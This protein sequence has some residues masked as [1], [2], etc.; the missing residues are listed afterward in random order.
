[1]SS[2][3]RLVAGLS[4][5]RPGFDPR[6]VHVG[7]VV[8][9]VALGQDFPRVLRFSPVSF[10]PPV[11]HYTEKRKTLIIFITGLHNKPQVCGASV[12][13]A[14]GSFKKTVC[15]P[16]KDQKMI[17]LVYPTL[18]DFRKSIAFRRFPAS[19]VCPSNK[20]STQLQMSIEHLWNDIDREKVKYWEKG[21]CRSDILNLTWTAPR[22]NS[23][24]R[25][26]RPVTKR[27]SRGMTRYQI[28]L[29]YIYKLIRT[30]Q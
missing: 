13:S 12:A 29:N 2:L 28:N 3:R 24:L 9:Q 1:V 26:E 18:P 6:S 21:T 8:D 11:L 25:C 10:F 7:F 14:A 19:P 4:P 5:R 20:T 30:A 22:L 17:V 16:F 15:W 27:L 23:G